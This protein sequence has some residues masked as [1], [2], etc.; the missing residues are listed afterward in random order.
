MGVQSFLM[1]TDEGSLHGVA[2]PT[3]THFIP[4]EASDSTITNSLPSQA[5]FSFAK[6]RHDTEEEDL[7]VVVSGAQ[8]KTN[9]ATRSQRPPFAGQRLA[10]RNPMF[11]RNGGN[12]KGEQTNGMASKQMRIT[13]MAKT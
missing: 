5:T 2:N 13:A 11:F 7:K 4:D 6:G 9:G 1:K 12:G 8:R 10:V 3:L